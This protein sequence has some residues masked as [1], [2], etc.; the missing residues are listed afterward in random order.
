MTASP[1]PRTMRRLL[2]ASLALNLLGLGLIAGAVVSG[3]PDGRQRGPEMAMGPL[4]RALDAEDRRALARALR[5]RDDLRGAG[6][7]DHEAAMSEIA[8]ALRADP[9]DVP[10]ARAAL[11]ERAAAIDSIEAGMREML[12]ARLAAM[13]REE[14]SALA[15]R[16]EHDAD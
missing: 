2:V 12:L 10:R 1:T 11:E 16:L 15:G 13:D 8:A 3:G 4:A 9:F 14:R 5:D 6:R 7:E